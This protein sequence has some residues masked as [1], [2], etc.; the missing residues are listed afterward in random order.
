MHTFLF[1][2]RLAESSIRDHV[3]E[4]SKTVP[5]NGGRE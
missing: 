1:A 5:R 4:G 3:L 2:R